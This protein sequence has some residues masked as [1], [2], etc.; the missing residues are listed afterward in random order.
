MISYERHKVS[1]TNSIIFISLHLFLL[2]IKSQIRLM[3]SY[4]YEFFDAESDIPVVIHIPEK[5]FVPY[6]PYI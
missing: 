6:L 3:M 2:M 4:Y 5:K 1:L